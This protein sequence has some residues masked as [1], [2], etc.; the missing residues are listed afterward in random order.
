M[1]IIRMLYNGI[2]SYLEL[3]KYNN[4]NTE[5][6]WDSLGGENIINMMNTWVLK[7][8]FPYLNVSIIG[9]N[10]DNI[11]LNVTQR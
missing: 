8:G 1:S 11:M 5:Q 6:L 3:Y 2:Q 9:N 7:S 4:A 10:D